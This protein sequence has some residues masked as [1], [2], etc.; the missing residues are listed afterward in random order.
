MTWLCMTVGRRVAGRR[1]HRLGQRLAQFTPFAGQAGPLLR[2]C[3]SVGVG[4]GGWVG[5]GCGCGRGRR[6]SHLVQP[7]CFLPARVSIGST[8]VHP[9]VVMHRQGR[10]LRRSREAVLRGIRERAPVRGRVEGLARRGGSAGPGRRRGRAGQGRRLGPGQAAAP[11]G[12]RGHRGEALGGEAHRARGREAVALREE[13]PLPHRQVGQQDL[14]ARRR[15]PSLG[16]ATSRNR[17][18]RCWRQWAGQVRRWV[19]PERRDLRLGTP[20]GAQIQRRRRA[21]RRVLP[22][23]C[24]TL[25]DSDPQGEMKTPAARLA[26][27]SRR[28][29]E[30]RSAPPWG[31]TTPRDCQHQYTVHTCGAQGD[32]YAVALDRPPQAAAQWVAQPVARAV[33]GRGSSGRRG[34]ARADG[35]DG[36]QLARRHGEKD[37]HARAT[38]VRWCCAR[39]SACARARAPTQQTFRP[40]PPVRRTAQAFAALGH[41]CARTATLASAGLV[42]EGVVCGSEIQGF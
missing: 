16:R 7:F 30:R 40:C 2:E 31:N 39:A 18:K 6:P 28:R 42:D 5:V 25:W 21:P 4:V 13:N 32:G 26:S 14:V 1:R 8:Q 19:V 38:H 29:L 15:A 11:R 22:P 9:I 41:S 12:V 33:M 37:P 23:R 34:T 36:W 24:A 10:E 27:S 20:L 35:G 17:P 3:V